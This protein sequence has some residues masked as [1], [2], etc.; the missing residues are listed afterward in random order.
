MMLSQNVL[1]FR[2]SATNQV[3]RFAKPLYSKRFQSLVPRSD[4]DL[5]FPGFRSMRPKLLGRLR[6]LESIR[7]PA[8]SAK[9][10]PPAVSFVSTFVS[11]A[12]AASAA[13]NVQ[14]DMLQN[15]TTVVCSENRPKAG[16]ISAVL[17]KNI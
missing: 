16:K 10:D 3:T 4:S 1:I 17:Q 6:S 15:L 13:I 8:S 2:G 14:R 9:R 7:R 11:P 12:R 5:L